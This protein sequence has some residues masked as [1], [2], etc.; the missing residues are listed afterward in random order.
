[1]SLNRQ[2][3]RG[4]MI[5]GAYTWSRAINWTDDDGWAGLDWND[6][7]VLRRNRAQAGYNIPHILQLAYIYEL[8]F[9]KGKSWVKDPGVLSAIAGGWQVS[10]IFSAYTGRPFT[11][12]ASNA[13]LNAPGQLQTADQIRPVVKLGGIGPGNAYYDP[14]SFAAVVRPGSGPNPYGTSGRNI[15]R[16]PGTVNMDFSLFRKFKFT[17]RLDLEL[18]ADAANLFNT[19]H[20]NNPNNSRAGANFLEITSARNDQRQFRFGLRLSF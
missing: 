4:L 16:G 18:R 3:S 1:M 19:P 9:G 17:E 10:G 20:F 15:L 12:T 11:V 14:S 5:K 8:P 6:P 7:D 13:S 2:F